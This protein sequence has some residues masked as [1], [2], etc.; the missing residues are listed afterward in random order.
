MHG[1]EEMR[2]N[3]SDWLAVSNSAALHSG[4]FR[5]ETKHDI[6]NYRR[7][8]RYWWGCDY[9]MLDQYA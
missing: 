4:V 1:I 5:P 9:L 6:E 3:V 2:M 7:Y 8:R